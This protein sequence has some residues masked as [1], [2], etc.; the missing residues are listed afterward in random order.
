MII[1]L[2]KMTPAILPLLE[3]LLG[4]IDLNSVKHAEKRYTKNYCL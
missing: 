3:L 1:V 4:V 2:M